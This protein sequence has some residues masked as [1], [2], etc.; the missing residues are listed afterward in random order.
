MQKEI[1]RE[2]KVIGVREVER[3]GKWEQKMPSFLFHNGFE[4]HFRSV[5]PW[6]Y[7]IAQSPLS[8]TSHPLPQR[9]EKEWEHITYKSASEW[10]CTSLGGSV[11]KSSHKLKSSCTPIPRT[12]VLNLPGQGTASFFFTL[13][14]SVASFLWHCEGP[15]Q[16]W[17]GGGEEPESKISSY[18]VFTFSPTP[19]V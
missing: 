8:L 6:A 7:W 2:E 10:S 3:R 18:F 4:G 17:R 12:W 9:I 14:V 15:R 19:S 1:D 5:W 11:S 16:I 13:H